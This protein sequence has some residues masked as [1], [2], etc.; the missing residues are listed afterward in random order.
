MSL[1]IAWFVVIAFFWLGY[2]FLE[3]FDFGVGMLLPVLG[4]DNTERRVMVNTIG[5]VWDGNE[6]WL[7]VAGG[8]MFAAFPA[9]Y[10]GLFSAAYLPLLLVLLALIGRGV[11]F[12]YR[13]KVDS[14]RWR[15]TWDR[16]IMIG[17]WIPPLGVGLI[18]ATTVLGL[19]L[20][21]E[22]NRVGSAFAAIRWDTLLGAVAIAAFSITHGAAFLALKTSGDLRERARTLAL[23]LLPI[24]MVPVVA[25]LSVVQWRA[26]TLWTLLA[27]GI[28]AVAA[29]VAWL[30][31]RA[32]RDGQAFAA[33]GVVIAGAAV[34]MFGSLF[35]NV[36]PS[37]LDTANT[38]TIEGAASSP[39]T[40]TV[41]TWVAV[42]GAPAVL[43]YQ[44][45]TYWVFRKRIGTQ[46]IPAVHAP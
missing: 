40:L 7:I 10:A 13:G 32:D 15:R 22:G 28:S 38:L 27:F 41:M 5:P 25:F 17:S 6:V 18:L 21:A 8:A 23:R 30:R 12:E 19:P 37:T 24:A 45:W 35:P 34:V 4:R 20:D 2:L 44:G 31:L 26:G 14:D 9:W 36:L 46:H 29:V 33:L 11:A 3:G 42:F 16:V 1:E 39:Y 43:I